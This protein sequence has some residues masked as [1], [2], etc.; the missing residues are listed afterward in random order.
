M[1]HAIT[2]APIERDR[3]IAANYHGTLRGYARLKLRYDPIYSAAAALLVE[4][5]APVLD[6]G[7]GIGLLGLYLRAQGFNRR[8]LG[9]DADALK[10][11]HARRSAGEHAATLTFENR[12]AV[13]LPAFSGS[14]AVLDVLHYFDCERQ[15]VLLRGAARRV[16]HDGVLVVRT[17]LQEPT[18]RY[19]ATVWEE[20]LLHGCGWM[21]MP[22]RHFPRRE[23][24]EST[25]G[26]V[27]MRVTIEPLWG[28]TPF[29]SFL[30]VAKRRSDA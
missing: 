22:A 10:V 24:I 16:A 8:Y 9:I 15:R 11:E 18:W 7:C 27:G 28:Y 17:A 25:L 1:S 19:R 13:V 21:R 12:D 26:D 14:V 23:E 5:D 30:I 4:A 2:A 6:I 29:A 3:G 20:R